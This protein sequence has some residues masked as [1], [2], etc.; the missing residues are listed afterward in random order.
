M[1]LC[2]CPTFHSLIFSSL[3]GVPGK[4][5]GTI[6][7]SAEELSNCRV[8]GRGTVGQDLGWG[9]GD[10]G[11][12]GLPGT[13]GPQ[14][15][16]GGNGGSQGSSVYLG[17]RRSPQLWSWKMSPLFRAELTEA[18]GE[19]KARP[20]SAAELGWEPWSTP[21]HGHAHLSLSQ[22]CLGTNTGSGEAFSVWEAGRLAF[23]CH[24]SLLALE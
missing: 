13:L 3:S 21:R 5:C 19:E 7:L 2:L 23:S 11:Q 18:Q 12:A 20:R 4:K 6:I 16:L 1:W 17:C 15:V 10:G 8:S 14:G 9:G 24:F 22:D